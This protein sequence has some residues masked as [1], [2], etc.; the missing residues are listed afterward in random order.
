MQRG[1]PVLP[2]GRRTGTVFDEGQC[3]VRA[4]QFGCQ[5]QRG[6]PI[7]VLGCHGGAVLDG[8]LG[9]IHVKLG[10]KAFSCQ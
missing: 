8:E 9:H 6:R 1:R 10:T 3:Q 4:T 5:M 2:L 7:L